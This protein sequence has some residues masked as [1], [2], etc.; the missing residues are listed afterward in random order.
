MK[1]GRIL[2]LII[3]LF[4]LI[5]PKLSYAQGQKE[6]TFFVNGYLKNMLSFNDVG[7]STLIDNLVHN[8]LDFK[9]YPN[10]NWYFHGALRTR[11]FA[12]D[13]PKNFEN[14]DEFLE[15]DTYFFDLTWT[16]W[17]ND[18]FL[19]HTMIDRLFFEYTKNDWDVKLGRQRIN[20]GINL[21]WNPNDIFNA[22]SYFD[23]DYEERPGTDAARVEYFTGTNSSI[24]FAITLPGE[25]TDIFGNTSSTFSTALMWK[26]NR[27]NYDFQ[28]LGGFTRENWVVG[29]GW[30]GNIKNAGFKGEI[31]YF[32]PQEE[33]D[34]DPESLVGS[35]SIDHTIG[36]FYY[37]VS[38]LYNSAGEV[39][40]GS[41]GL[42][43]IS[44]RALTAKNLSPYRHSGFLQGS[45]QFHP[46]WN[47]GL[48]VM[49]FPPNKAFFLSPFVTWN[50]LQ[51]FDVDFI[52]QSFWGEEFLTNEFKSLSTSYFF[53]VKWSF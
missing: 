51:N 49:V 9:W 3:S 47:A 8:R 43:A 15:Y 40:L 37:N 36:D 29:T 31:S 32:L 17:Q 19:L 23:F 26:T 13:T 28:L 22:Y 46:L 24:D 7:D 16:I 30:A 44:S 14:F 2:I 42:I 25:T 41:E 18:A 10:D 1:A 6:K 20:W 38:Y 11:F 53:R 34:L 12:G 5:I 4:L 21:V 45:Y 50:M 39:R 33:T 27:W 35:V 48:G 52:V